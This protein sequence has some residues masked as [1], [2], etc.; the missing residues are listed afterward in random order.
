MTVVKTSAERAEEVTTSE[1]ARE[2]SKAG[3]YFRI[4]GLQM[5]ATSVSA[6]QA[7]PEL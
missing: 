4:R 2:D 5:T 6:L 7:T 3:I 1:E